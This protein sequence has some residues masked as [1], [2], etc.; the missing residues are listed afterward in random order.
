[1]GD[2]DCDDGGG[3]HTDDDGGDDGDDGDDVHQQRADPDSSSA[4]WKSPTDFCGFN[5]QTIQLQNN[6]S[7]LILKSKMSTT[8]E[9]RR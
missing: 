5:F 7:F 8:F 6:F 4:L 2:V 3:G 9:R 1:M